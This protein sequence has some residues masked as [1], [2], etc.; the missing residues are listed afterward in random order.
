MEGSLSGLAITRTVV[1]VA[2]VVGDAGWERIHKEKKVQTA[3]FLF[4]LQ[5]RRG[6]WCG[7]IHL[8]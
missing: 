6:A 7:Q 5:E 2:G 8:H 1:V 4:T 3:K